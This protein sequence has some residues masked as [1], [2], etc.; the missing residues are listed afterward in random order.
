RG[1]EVQPANLYLTAGT[2]EAVS[3]LIKLF[4]NV[5]DEILIQAPGYPL[6]DFIANLESVV[7]IKY[8]LKRKELSPNSFSYSFD[9]DELE[10][11]RSKKTKICIVVQP[12][13]PIGKNL[14]QK[15]ADRILEFCKKYKIILLIDEVF[16]DYTFNHKYIHFNSQDTPVITMSGFSKVLGLPQLKLS[17]MYLEG[18]KKF[19]EEAGQALEII[20]DTY[21]SVNTQVMVGASE[22]LSLREKIQDQILSRIEHNLTL[23]EEMIRNQKNVSYIKPDGGWYIVLFFQT[24]FTDEEFCLNLLSQK[25]VYVHPGYM[26]EFSN[27]GCYIVI[28]LITSTEVFIEG[29]RRIAEF[30]E[31]L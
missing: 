10:A 4:C 6:Y 18:N 16:A 5:G 13:N 14:N 7:A 2:S 8:H 28:S 12:N 29:L 20:T 31:T 15:E 9:F 1:K 26:F 3:H 19:Q 23:L 22:L 24:D 21:L 25:S 27:E 30:I 11:K 17:W